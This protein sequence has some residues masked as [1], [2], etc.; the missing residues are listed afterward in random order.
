MLIAEFFAFTDY[1]SGQQCVEQKISV[2]RSASVASIAKTKIAGPFPPIRQALVDF[3]QAF[4]K[5]HCELPKRF[6]VIESVGGCPPHF[7]HL[8]RSGFPTAAFST[9][10]LQSSQ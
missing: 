9:G 10:W 2:I 7:E 8:S 1:T 6:G 3:R 5:K 4:I